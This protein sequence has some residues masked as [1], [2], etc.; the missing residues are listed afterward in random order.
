MKDFKVVLMDMVKDPQLASVA[1]ALGCFEEASADQIY[2]E[3]VS[4]PEEQKDKKEKVVLKNSFGR[5][6][7]SVGDQNHFIFSI[8]GLPRA[9]TLHLCLPEYLAHLQQSLRRAKPERGFYI[10]EAIRESGLAVETEEVLLKGFSFYQRVTEQGGLPGEDARFPLSLYTKTN[11]QTAGNA[12]ELSHLWVMA[13]DEEVPSVVKAVVD[14]MLVLAKM[15]A[16]YLFED[17]GFNYERLAWYPSAILY[18]PENKMLQR[19]I[20][21]NSQHGDVILIDFTQGA[22]DMTED[23]IGK[24]IR[25]HDEA[26]LANLKHLHFEFLVSM[27]IVTFHQAIRQRTWNHSVEP[28]YFAAEKAIEHP[29]SWEDMIIEPPSIGKSDFSPEYSELCRGMLVLYKRLVDDGIPM[30]EA[31]G[32]MPHS[33]KIWTLIHVNGWNALHSVGKRTCL[34]AQWEIRRK[35][36]KIAKIIG[37]KYPALGKWIGPQCVVYGYCPEIEDCGY[38]QEFLRKK[39]GR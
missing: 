8:E 3:I 21:K 23:E 2:Q 22:V 24:A 33:L 30:S 5:G 10:P 7:G 17:F 35:A 34:T 18:A 39:E 1:G 4:L 14:E 38:Y 25:N 31:I 12:R 32:V 28:I 27:S 20:E 6:H 9:A 26:A 36:R 29:N 16:P 37:E 13:Q 19:L 15:E 11:I